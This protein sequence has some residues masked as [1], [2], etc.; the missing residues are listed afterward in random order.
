MNLSEPYNSITNY[1]LEKL[2]FE[3]KLGDVFYYSCLPLCVVDSIFSIGVRYEGVKNV[4][5]NVSVY[6]NIPISLEDKNQKPSKEKQLSV[7]NFLKKIENKTPKDLATQ[8]FKNNQRTSSTNGI[9]KSEAVVHFLK[10]LKEFNVEFFQDV[11]EVLD[12]NGFESA[13]KNIKGQSS[14]ISLKYFYMLAGNEDLIKPDR[15][16]FRFLKAATG[17]EF[18]QAEAQKILFDTAIELSKRLNRKVSASYLDNK[19]W[20]YQRLL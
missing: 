17:K 12:R 13:I 6:F 15:M 18:N 9:L 10:I 7:S 3:E 20:T 2:S 11:D 16:I 1:C 8:V 19:I 14:G 4:I 5:N